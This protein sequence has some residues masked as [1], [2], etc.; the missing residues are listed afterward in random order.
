VT[1]PSF[2]GPPTM[3]VPPPGWVSC[4]DYS[5]PDTHPIDNGGIGWNFTKRAFDG[6]T[7]LGLVMRGSIGA[8]NDY[9]TEAAGNKLTTPLK[10]NSCYLLTVYLS[11]FLDAEFSTGFELIKY[12]NPGYLIIWGST[13]ACAK[14]QMIWK[15]PII[16]NEDWL[17]FT[18]QFSNN[19]DKNF[20]YLILEAA[21]ADPNQKKYGNILIDNMKI[22]ENKLGNLGEDRVICEGSQVV[23]TIPVG[24]DNVVWWNGS[25]EPTI[26][27]NKK[28]V[29]WAKLVKGSCSLIDSVIVNSVKPLG[30]ILEADT[31]LCLGDELSVDVATPYGTYLWSTGSE[32]S[33]I[34]IAHADKY[35]VTVTNQCNSATGNIS[36]SYREPC[37]QISA[38][39][40]F[41][42]N[43]DDYNELFEISTESSILN[44]NMSIFN[45][46]GQLVFET[47]DIRNFWNGKDNGAEISSGVYFWFSNFKCQHVGKTLESKFRGSVTVLR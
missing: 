1:N 34:V 35:K 24:T 39:N 22:E 7:Y 5:T 46:W 38:P 19:T 15:S 31:S 21:Y 42:P 36:V 6:N 32:K 14:Q 10:K 9:L 44:Y 25:T 45:R 47:N 37:C 29:Y 30:R 18:F 20:D 8:V 26:S 41:T 16:S 2:E 27:A 33:K 17:P 40:V 43:G 12:N 23:L 28:G 13:T 4:G 3:S 11:T